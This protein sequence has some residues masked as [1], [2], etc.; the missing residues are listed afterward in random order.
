M[1]MRR[2]TT[3][4]FLKRTKSGAGLDRCL[5]FEFTP[6]D[7]CS[8]NCGKHRFDHDPVHDL[9]I[10]E[11]LDEKPPEQFFLFA[12]FHHECSKGTGPVESEEKRIVEKNLIK[13]GR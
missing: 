6:T 9:P 7:N 12:L 13:I 1:L 5:S 11:T 3:A 4:I 10:A 2:N 8:A